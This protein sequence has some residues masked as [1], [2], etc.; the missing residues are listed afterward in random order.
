MSLKVPKI[1]KRLPSSE[2]ETFV[3]AYNFTM[4]QMDDL[5]DKAFD[6]EYRGRRDIAG[7]HYK[8]GNI[9][10]Y[11]LYYGLA[12]SNFIKRESQVV[13]GD[14]YSV[15]AEKYDIACVEKNLECLSSFHGVD[16]VAFWDELKG[17]LGI[18]DGPSSEEN[19]CPGLGQMIITGPNCKVFIVGGCELKEEPEP[20]NGAFD[21]CGFNINSFSPSVGDGIYDECN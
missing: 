10:I 13:E 19:C 14:I 17:Y 11:L 21:A 4:N 12:V 15:M 16:Y 6:A 1:F 3:D 5:L 18:P 20:P 9:F 8:G 2:E 7:K